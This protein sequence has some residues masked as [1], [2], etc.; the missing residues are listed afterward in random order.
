MKERRAFLKALAPG[1][2]VTRIVERYY[3]VPNGVI[4][5]E[6]DVSGD[7]LEL[8]AQARAEWE[9]EREAAEPDTPVEPVDVAG[10]E[11]CCHEGEVV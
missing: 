4:A 11:D 7:V 2:F 3:G 9:K 6:F 8:V 10:S 5:D 1:V